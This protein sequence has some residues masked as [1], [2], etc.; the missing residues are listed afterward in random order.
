MGIVI[1]IAI[2]IIIDS[3][4]NAISNIIVNIGNE[5]YRVNTI[6]KYRTNIIGNVRI[7]NIRKK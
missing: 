1:K 3:I 2:K 4:D 6:V 5:K 7:K